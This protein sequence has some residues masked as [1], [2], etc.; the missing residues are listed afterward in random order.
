MTNY[1]DDNSEFNFFSVVFPIIVVFICF[2]CVIIYTSK[3]CR[4]KPISRTFIINEGVRPGY[5]SLSG[6]ASVAVPIATP[7]LYSNNNNVNVDIPTAVVS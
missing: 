3:A 5:S 6:N 1:Y 4:S 7:V 2:S